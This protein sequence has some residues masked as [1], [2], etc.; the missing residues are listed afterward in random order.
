MSYF[1]VTRE[2]G[3]A[4]DHS[5]PMD[6]QKAWAEHAAFM[7]SLVDKG[8]VVLGGPLGDGLRVLLVIDAEN[9]AAIRSR[10][11]EDPWT[12]MRL[13]PIAGIEP[14]RILLGEGP[15]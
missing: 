13:L 6:E 3:P 4:W 1:V 7:N 8:F 2:R 9:E 10:I 11:D 15:A 5:R 12:P 14:W